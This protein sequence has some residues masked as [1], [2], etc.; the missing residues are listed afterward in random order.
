MS[1]DFQLRACPWRYKNSMGRAATIFLCTD[2]IETGSQLSI[3][4]RKSIFGRT[5][6][7]KKNCKGWGSNSYLQEIGMGGHGAGV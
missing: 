1:L 4:A 3:D 6:L 2:K 5:Q 7:E